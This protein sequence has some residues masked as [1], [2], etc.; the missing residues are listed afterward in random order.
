MKRVTVAILLVVG[1]LFIVM[2]FSNTTSAVDN[3]NDVEHINYKNTYNM[4]DDEYIVY[5]WQES[6]KYCLEVKQDVNQYL[7]QS[8]APIYIVDMK[9]TSNSNAWYN[10]EFHHQKYDQKIG[11]IKDGEEVL[12]ED[13][14]LSDFEN[15]K[16][17]DW[18]I[19]ITESNELIAHHNTPYANLEPNSVDE[20]EITGTPTMLKIK[21]GK[22]EG[23][24]VGVEQVRKLLV[25]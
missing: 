11:T 8:S 12:D 18:I 4:N 3:I 7:Q 17:V 22:L 21:N 14:D 15:D 2:K 10:W 9:D 19:E 23:Y 16:N 6:C 13:I 5:F 25:K 1:L 20:L 24:A